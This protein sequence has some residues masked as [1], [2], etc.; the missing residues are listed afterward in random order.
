MMRFAPVAKP[1]GFDA[2]AE[3][4]ARWLGENPG[5]ARPRDFWSPFRP[6]L[7]SGFGQL[8]AYGVMYEPVGTV[9]HFVSWHEDRSKAYEWDNYRFASQWINSSK[10]KLGSHEILDPFAVEDAWFEILLP[11][12]QMIATAAV[13]DALRDR[14]ETMLTRL[15]LRDD[16]R[17][18]R[19]R[20]EWYRMY[21]ENELTLEGLRKKA[22][23]I[24]RAV[25]RRELARTQG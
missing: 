9:D 22:P 25:D 4:G 7:A 17:I 15:H 1:E 23:L 3:L 19:Q 20:R 10:Q 12:L 16:E 14:V 11:S 2:K 21:Q 5:A 13:P 18:L 6:A 24:A 8:C